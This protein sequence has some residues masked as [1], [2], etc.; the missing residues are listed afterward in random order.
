MYKNESTVLFDVLSTNITLVTVFF[1][2]RLCKRTLKMF[3]R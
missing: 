2:P 1:P 3:E